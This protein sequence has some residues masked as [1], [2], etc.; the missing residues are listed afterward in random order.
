MNCLKGTISSLDIEKELIIIKIAI[1]EQIFRVLML[2]FNSFDF[3]GEV[4]LLFKEHELCFGN[5]DTKLS[6]EN[7]FEAKIKRIEKGKLLWQV[8]FDFMGFEL[9][10]IISAEKGHELGIF[11]GEQK[12][13]FVKAND[14]ILRKS[15][16]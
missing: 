12:L 13:C 10:A 5:L 14:I 7:S 9:S 1:K 3:E 4:D 11:E 15:N 16:A 2:D 6:V 8:F